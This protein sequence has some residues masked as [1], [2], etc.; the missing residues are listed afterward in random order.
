MVISKFTKPSD[1]TLTWFFSF[2]FHAPADVSSTQVS[3]L[4]IQSVPN[5]FKDIGNYSTNY[6]KI[7]NAFTITSGMS[8]PYSNGHA[9]VPTG[10]TPKLPNDS[11]V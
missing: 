7:S 2:H 3:T 5:E 10:A 6:G 8:S 4:S 11:K 9:F 1:K